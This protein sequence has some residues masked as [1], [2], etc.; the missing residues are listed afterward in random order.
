MQKKSVSLC[1][2]GLPGGSDSKEST[3]NEADVGSISR[4]GRSPGGGYGNP[5]QYSCLE[6]RHRQRTLAG[7]SPW[8]CKESEMTKR[9][10]TAQH[11][12]CLRQGEKK[13]KLMRQSVNNLII[14]MVLQVFIELF[15]QHFCKCNTFQKKKL[16][17]RKR[18]KQ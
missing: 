18:N 3:C 6:N 12:M 10:S 4:L 1:V 2:W 8:G 15:L 11:N 5:L 13:G 14:W 7:Y 16:G 9:L 17:R